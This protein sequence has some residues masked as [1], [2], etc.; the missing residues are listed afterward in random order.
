M[1]FFTHPVYKEKH[2]QAYI[3][4]FCKVA[5]AYSKTPAGVRD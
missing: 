1:S 4:A 5:D 2:M 3:D